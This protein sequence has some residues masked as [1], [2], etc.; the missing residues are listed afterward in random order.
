MPELKAPPAPPPLPSVDAKGSQHRT[1]PPSGKRTPA[2]VPGQA[3]PVEAA[4]GDLLTF[5][6]Q[7]IG[8]YN[9]LAPKLS[10]QLEQTQ[11]EAEAAQQAL[12]RRHEAAV[13]DPV[14]RAEAVVALANR[15]R[16][17]LD[18][19]QIDPDRLRGTA[20]TT[21][22][23]ADAN[24]R[25]TQA[26]EI[27]QRA[28]TRLASSL[29]SPKRPAWLAV[30][31]GIEAAVGAN[32]LLGSLLAIVLSPLVLALAVVAG[33]RYLAS[34]T[35]QRRRM[36]AI[37]S[38]WQ[39]LL[40]M[41]TR[42]VV[43]RDALVSDLERAH[44]TEAERAAAAARQTLSSARTNHGDWLAK[45]D[46]QRAA[47]ERAVEATSPGWSTDYWRQRQG[48]SKRAPG[49]RFGRLTSSEGVVLPALVEFPGSRSLVFRAPAVAR[50]HAISAMRNLL[51]RALTNTPPGKLRL[52][53][54]DPLGLGQSVA[55]FMR[56]SDHDEQLVGPQAWIESEQ[57]DRCL[58]DL[59]Q[60]MSTV[61]QKYLRNQ[62]ATIDEYNA[63]A[64]EV[65]EPFRVLVVVDFPTKFSPDAC[66]RLLSI[67]A[68]GPRCGVNCLLLTDGSKPDRTGDDLYEQLA[69]NADIVTW[70][71]DGR[72]S[73]QGRPEC[74][75]W[76]LEPESPPVPAVGTA[77]LDA[78]GRQARSATT[79][80][81]SWK[82]VLAQAKLDTPAT[83]WS[84]NSADSLRVP[85]GPA[86]ARRLQYLELGQ[87]TAHHVLVG[88]RVGSGKSTLLH[89][90]IAGLLRAYGPEELSLYLL[91][92]KK[93]VEFKPYAAYR[94][95]QVR[96]VG[97]ESEREFGVS[98]LEALDRELT[99]RGELFRSA[100]ADKLAKYRAMTGGPLPRVLLVVDEFH[101]LFA[102][103]D[104]LGVRAAQL[105]DRLVRQGRAFGIHLLLG[106]QSLGGN[107][108]LARS[109]IDQMGVRIALQCSEADSRLILADDNPA[110]RLLGRPGQAVYNANSGHKDN[111][112]LFQVAWLDDGERQRWLSELASVKGVADDVV[113]F[114]GNS[115]PDAQHNAE[116]A[117]LIGTT[118]SAR[119][120][121][122]MVCLGTPVAI[123]AATMVALRRQAGSNLV[124]VSKNSD[125][126]TALANLSLLSL[127][128][129]LP[130]ADATFYLL[131][132]SKADAAGHGRLAKF[133]AAIPHRCSVGR[134][135]E[136]PA[137][138]EEV[139][140]TLEKRVGLDDA[141]A[142]PA[143]YLII[144]GVQRARDLRAD[145]FGLTGVAE[146]S[147]SAGF[148]RIVTD[149]PDV[150][151]HTLL[152]VDTYTNLSR[153][154]DHRL[155]R[156]FDLRVVSQMGQQ[157]SGNL[158]ESTAAA[159]LGPHV[160][161]LYDEGE[162]RSEKFRPFSL[163]DCEWMEQIAEMLCKRS[164]A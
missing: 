75:D 78:I 101:E 87:G 3:E 83:W 98:V 64:G 91:D 24:A 26:N 115:S 122:G 138:I 39:L 130:P 20:P 163:P 66:A 103:D 55:E 17:E 77:I 19:A 108:M 36:S 162:N 129:G 106:S 128:S 11:R 94:P 154:V 85:L 13:R 105:L 120:P 21:A 134:K 25:L 123:K 141:A 147:P 2:T 60:H 81:V 15:A 73:W 16:T 46:A 117:G 97:I 10:A 84:W 133:G 82:Q 32:R 150:G 63:E 59:T 27:A 107:Y 12:A 89:T 164:T 159:Q 121:V 157:D 158:V 95:P 30:A 9:A 41:R 14:R 7:L 104:A 100:G 68:N 48:A 65:A 127:A 23:P 70:G 116:L 42:A 35:S 152:T 132:F 62:F 145:P 53:L 74:N 118:W 113:V 29:P 45:I 125:M 86:G 34:L 144:D 18:R 88:G 99:R 92:F 76:T 160:A 4:V 5:Q 161:L 148:A 1:E 110:G 119:P 111:N 137:F 142:C 22:P 153:V 49:V 40:A 54:I 156:E 6:R 114:E 44:R 126:A 33:I 146:D 72:V 124:V 80:Q 51:F 38:D 58:A 102:H 50:V 61:I 71:E 96:V 155:L 143:V 90:I 135:R 52:T 112:S 140:K 69:H 109:T 93:G 47:F 57:I 28:A 31:K 8:A 151:I 149:G 79:V 139:A 67:M 43:A 136:L 131:D 56:L 37:A